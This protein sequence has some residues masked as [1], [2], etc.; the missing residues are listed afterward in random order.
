MDNDNSRFNT[1][2]TPFV[3]ASDGEQ[4]PAPPLITTNAVRRGALVVDM[5]EAAAGLCGESQ[6]LVGSQPAP[7]SH[8]PDILLVR[9]DARRATP[10]SVD[11]APTSI[12]VA[13]VALSQRSP[14]VL[15]QDAQ[16]APAGPVR[17]EFPEFPS[18]T[19]A[20]SSTTL[21][22]TVSTPSMNAR[23]SQALALL[24]RS[25]IDN[26]EAIAH[27]EIDRVYYACVYLQGCVAHYEDT[28]RVTIR[29]THSAYCRSV[30]EG[31]EARDIAQ[32]RLQSLVSHIEAFL[33]TLSVCE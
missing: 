32:A 20:T 16:D 27:H 26:L 17:S 18:S 1:I 31:D 19:D 9:P 29:D 33:P 3:T 14:P 28:F 2:D 15:A 30:D 11:I 12:M 25:L 23:S 6:P 10:T 7:G 21:A 8:A 4:A 5:D 24:A 22:G 13:N